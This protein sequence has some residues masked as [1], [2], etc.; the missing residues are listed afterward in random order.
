MNFFICKRKKSPETDPHINGKS[1][2]EKIP[3]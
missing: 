3:T 1:V 2:L